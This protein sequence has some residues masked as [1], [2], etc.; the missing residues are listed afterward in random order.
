MNNFAHKKK[1]HSWKNEDKSIILIF[2]FL[3]KSAINKCASTR[4]KPHQLIIPR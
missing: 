4:T 1:M 2:Y 3:E